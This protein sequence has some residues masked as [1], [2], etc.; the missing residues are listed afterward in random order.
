MGIVK[1]TARAAAN[2][3][4]KTVEKKQE[5]RWVR[6]H[7]EGLKNKPL[8]EKNRSNSRDI[9][10]KRTSRSNRPFIATSRKLG[11]SKSGFGHTKPKGQ[12][13][14]KTTSFR[15]SKLNLAEKQYRDKKIEHESPVF[16]TQTSLDWQRHYKFD[17]ALGFQ[18]S[19][20]S[21]RNINDTPRYGYTPQQGFSTVNSTGPWDPGP[22]SV[23][24]AESRW[25]NK[26]VT[27]LTRLGH[28]NKGQQKYTKYTKGSVGYGLNPYPGI[29][30][31]K[32]VSQ[33]QTKRSLYRERGMSVSEIIAWN[34][35][36]KE[37]SQ[38]DNEL[39]SYLKKWDKKKNI[40]DKM[41][42][43]Y[44]LQDQLSNQLNP[45][46]DTNNRPLFYDKRGTVYSVT[47]PTINKV[48]LKPKRK[49]KRLTREQRE[50]QSSNRWKI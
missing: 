22:V 4:K 35:K 49:K 10:I 43:K 41:K 32:R 7:K 24:A 46:T 38:A 2:I 40:P 23:S 31:E 50:T 42:M 45:L 26:E 44:A 25:L 34:A 20:P 11:S 19:K 3:A 29:S 14:G 15:S 9:E 28:G 1:I 16:K 18:H 48:K 5:T 39:V 47:E 30:I 8:I 17:D 27:P 13:V 36:R 37:T 21:L 6:Q 33:I 12:P